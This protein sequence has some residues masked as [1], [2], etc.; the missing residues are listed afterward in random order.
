MK[1][2]AWILVIISILA[3]IALAVYSVIITIQSFSLPIYQ[4][5]LKV[6]IIDALVLLMGF[7]IKVSIDRRE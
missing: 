7:K 1:T 4:V 2:V 5:P 6:F 3:C